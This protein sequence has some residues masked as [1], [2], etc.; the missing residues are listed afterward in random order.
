MVA[1]QGVGDDGGA[2]QGVG[3]AAVVPGG[4]GVRHHRV[5]T[6]GITMHVAESGP[7]DG[8]LV[9]LCHGFPECWYSWRHQ[10]RALG[11][12]G[13][14]VL[15]PDQRGYGTTD[16]PAGVD[17]YT[18]LHLVGDIV[19]LLDAFGI[20]EAGIVGHDWG[21]PVAWHAALLRPDRIRAVAS[22][23]THCAPVNPLATPHVDVVD[24]MR[25]ALG[26]DFLYILYF[27]EPGVA[28][29]ELDADIRRTLRTLYGLSGDLPREQVRFFDPR[30]RSFADLVVEPPGPLPWL[31]E[32]DL[33]VYEE[34]FAHHGT[35]A[36]GLNWYRNIGRNAELLAPF[37]G[38]RVE[39][40]ALFI[41]AEFDVMFGQTR[42]RV[43]AT[44]DH[45]PKLRDPVW[46]EGSGHW[47]AQ[48]KPEIVNRLLLDFLGD[49]LA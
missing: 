19:G 47:I 23:S 41:G 32:V 14:H 15:A 17:R 2:D 12:A 33:D 36:G 45:V 7:D 5:A 39:Q 1:D 37:A 21:G 49:E 40:P 34:T 11:E 29:A 46:V 43:L 27:Q 38:A 16:M 42:E 44:R 31:S 35:F 10:L 18:Q 20:G 26:D 28:E 13:F 30:A 9:V 48:E 25:T 22:L 8:P 24:A 3:D 4:H 6:N